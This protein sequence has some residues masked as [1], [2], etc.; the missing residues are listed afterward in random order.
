MPWFFL[1][2]GIIATHD[3]AAPI[4]PKGWTSVTTTIES[5]CLEQLLR[6]ID[7]KKK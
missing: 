4:H 6:M 1:I 3:C 7:R 5:F 2:H